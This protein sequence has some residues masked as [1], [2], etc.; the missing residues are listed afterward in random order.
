MSIYV[1]CI[2]WNREVPNW[3]E[4]FFST[5]QTLLLPNIIHKEGTKHFDDGTELNEVNFEVEEEADVPNNVGEVIAEPEMPLMKSNE[6]NEK[7]K[8]A[9]KSSSSIFQETLSMCQP[10]PFMLASLDTDHLIVRLDDKESPKFQLKK[11]FISCFFCKS[12][13]E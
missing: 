11:L 2:N 13:K 1:S 3:Y 12:L 4:N 5:V 8:N 7:V 9:I 6:E 10:Y